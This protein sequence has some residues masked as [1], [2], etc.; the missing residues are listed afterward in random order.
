[1]KLALDVLERAGVATVPGEDFGLPGTLRLSFT[2][3]RF[4]EAINRLVGY[5]RGSR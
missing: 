2:A 5:F 1:V 3:S 4:D